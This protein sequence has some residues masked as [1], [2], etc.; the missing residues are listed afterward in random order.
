LTPVVQK[1]GQYRQTD[2][3]APVDAQSKTRV[4]IPSSKREL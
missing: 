4:N 1:Q 3:L 2:Y